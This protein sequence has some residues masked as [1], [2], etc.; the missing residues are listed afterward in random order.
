[1]THNPVAA[2]G[3]RRINS[4]PPQSDADDIATNLITMLLHPLIVSAAGKVRR[5]DLSGA[6]HTL[7]RAPANAVSSCQREGLPWRS[8]NGQA[9]IADSQ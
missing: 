6:R 7:R 5:G 3:S 4:P 2:D 9:P 8:E 1:M